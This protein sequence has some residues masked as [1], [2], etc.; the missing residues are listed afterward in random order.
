MEWLGPGVSFGGSIRPFSFL[1]LLS[2]SGSNSRMEQLQ[3]AG[4]DA[5]GPHGIGRMKFNSA[6]NVE[7]F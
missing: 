1:R 5:R 7:H 4:I 2:H 3:Y 6:L